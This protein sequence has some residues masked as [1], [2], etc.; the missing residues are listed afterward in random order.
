VSEGQAGK[1]LQIYPDRW[2]YF[3]DGV[4]VCDWRPS[5]RVYK[6]TQ[7]LWR[8]MLPYR[9]VLC[10]TQDAARRVCAELARQTPGTNGES[11]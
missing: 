8:S 11:G 3:V 6:V 2:G 7:Y 9:T 5:G 1:F 10:S 4:C